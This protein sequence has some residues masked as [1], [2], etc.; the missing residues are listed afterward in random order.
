YFRTVWGG[1]A[2]TQNIAVAPGTSDFTTFCVTAPTNAQ[3]PG[4]GGYQLCGLYDVNQNKF[5]Q[6]TTVVSAAPTKN[7]NQTEVYNGF[8]F[9]LNIRLTRRIYIN[10]GLNTG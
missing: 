7:G 2:A 9:I 3:L 5:G 10:G 6:S 4:G 8:D 1:F